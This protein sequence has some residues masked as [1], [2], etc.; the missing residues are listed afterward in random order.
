MVS[1]SNTGAS[2]SPVPIPVPVAGIANRSPCFPAE[3]RL[4]L[5]IP[6]FQIAP[7]IDMQEHARYNLLAMLFSFPS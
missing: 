2:V 5:F 4:V 3:P 6:L 1:Q 7:P